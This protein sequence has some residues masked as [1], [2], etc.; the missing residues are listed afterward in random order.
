MPSVT[1]AEVFAPAHEY[2]DTPEVISDSKGDVA[3][4]FVDIV[5]VEVT[6]E[7]E[8]VI[9]HIE[10]ADLPERLTFN[11]AP[12]NRGEYSWSVYIDIDG[13]P[14]TGSIYPEFFGAD[15]YLGVSH[16]VPPYAKVEVDTLLGGCSARI[17]RATE[18]GFSLE[19][20][21]ASAEVDYVTNTLTVRGRVPGL[22]T[23]VF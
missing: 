15:Y 11:K 9:A 10:L 16:F 18:E 13:N 8:E 20:F 14:N 7:G 4:D 3:F 6:L 21:T 2:F 19:H 12:E 22:N 17:Y 23:N 5:S 1:T